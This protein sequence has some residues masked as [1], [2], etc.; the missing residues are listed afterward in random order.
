MNPTLEDQI[1][2][3]HAMHL[4]QSA[5]VSS[6]LGC[7]Q[8]VTDALRPLSDTLPDVI[9]L[10]LMQRKMLLQS[11]LENLETTQPEFAAR[12]QRVIDDSCKLYP[13]DYD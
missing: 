11:H 13:F 5:D 8:A 12:L 6:V 7:I 10:F 1:L 2:H 9:A 4:V 3:L